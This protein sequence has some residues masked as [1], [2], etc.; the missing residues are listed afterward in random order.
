MT[1]G[2]DVWKRSLPWDGLLRA[3][4]LDESS[5]IDE[6][7]RASNRDKDCLQSSP[8]RGPRH[9]FSSKFFC[10][11]ALGMAERPSEARGHDALA[12]S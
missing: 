3:E 5:G 1:A 8:Q 7:L 10:F 2:A 4:P 11:D 9:N 12:A 6:P